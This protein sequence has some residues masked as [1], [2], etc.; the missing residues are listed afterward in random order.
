ML[1][2]KCTRTTTCRF[3]QLCSVIDHNVVVVRSV[4]VNIAVH[5]VLVVLSTVVL[6]VILDHAA[7]DARLGCGVDVDA[8]VCAGGAAH[9]FGG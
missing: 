3:A 6:A 4:H 8:R 1:S 2:P 5:V 7:V 9:L